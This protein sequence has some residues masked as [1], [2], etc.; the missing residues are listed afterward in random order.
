M[1]VS[2]YES[3]ENGTLVPPRDII[4]AICPNQCSGNGN[5][6]KG[7]CVC[8]QNYTSVDCSVK[9]GELAVAEY[10]PDEGLCDVRKRVCQETRVIGKHFLNSENLT[11]SVTTL[12]VNAYEIPVFRSFCFTFVLYISIKKSN[13]TMGYS[14]PVLGAFVLFFFV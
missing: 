1:N 12:T 5:C 4:E 10:I 11:C 7:S 3:G 14:S 13:I 6:T 8:Y 2:N 9:I